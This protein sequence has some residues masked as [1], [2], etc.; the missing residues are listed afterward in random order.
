MLSPQ[1]LEPQSQNLSLYLL[2]LLQLSTCVVL[3]GSLLAKRVPLVASSPPPP[4]GHTH[5]VWLRGFPFPRSCQGDPFRKFRPTSQVFLAA[6][7][8]PSP[9]DQA[10]IVSERE[11]GSAIANLHLFGLE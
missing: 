7:F 1:Y 4:I 10:C 3:R 8:P 9:I 2:R 11:F 5:A 6:F